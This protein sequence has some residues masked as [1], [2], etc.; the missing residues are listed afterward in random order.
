MDARC[1]VLVIH[2]TK[3]KLAQ[4]SLASIKPGSHSW[5]HRSAPS[6]SCQQKLPHLPSLTLKA[7]RDEAAPFGVLSTQAVSTSTSAL[8]RGSK[9]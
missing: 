9:D 4:S 7:K 5:A 1:V 3:L 2:T 8:R 6:T